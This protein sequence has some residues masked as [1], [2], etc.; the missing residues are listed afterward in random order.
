MD[1]KNYFSLLVLIT[2][3]NSYYKNFDEIFEVN[4]KIWNKSYL[5]W[6]YLNLPT[7]LNSDKNLVY[8]EFSGAFRT[9]KSISHFT[10]EHL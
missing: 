8:Y 3:C 6:S 5:T 7:N 9:W 2:V 4:N 1:C 10:F